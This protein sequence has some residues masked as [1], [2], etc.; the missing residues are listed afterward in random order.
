[1]KAHKRLMRA[2][3]DLANPGREAENRKFNQR[4][5]KGRSRRGCYQVR[6]TPSG[7]FIAR[8]VG[9]EFLGPISTKEM[10]EFLMERADDEL[11]WAFEASKIV[12]RKQAREAVR[13][14]LRAEMDGAVSALQK[15]LWGQSVE[16]VCE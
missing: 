11:A 10:I 1:M 9:G 2:L 3:N 6:Q 13:D 8:H 16:V 15:T 4:A 5:G 7:S 12:G 14:T